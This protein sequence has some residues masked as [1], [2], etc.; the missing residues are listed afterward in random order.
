MKQIAIVMSLVFSVFVLSGCKGK[1]DKSGKEECD[2]KGVGWVWNVTEEKCEE[3]AATKEDC[4]KKGAGWTW[5]EANKKCNQVTEGLSLK[6][7]CEAKGAGWT[8][9]EDKATDAGEE[10]KK[11]TK[12]LSAGCTDPAKPIAIRRNPLECVA[13]YYVIINSTDRNGLYGSDSMPAFSFPEGACVTIDELSFQYYSDSLFIRLDYEVRVTLGQQMARV[14]VTGNDES[15][16]EC[17]SEKGVYELSIDRTFNIDKVDK[18]FE[19]LKE[20]GC[21]SQIIE[22]KG[23]L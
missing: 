23:P 4:D 7:K 9:N 15:F 1:D 11:C 20:M 12:D 5:D 8:W 14:C 21:F 10:Y 2:K 13:P 3:A 17:P 18:T 19:E 22:A 16:V 6:E